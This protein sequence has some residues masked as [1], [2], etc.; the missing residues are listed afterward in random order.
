MIQ[1]GDILRVPLRGRA[2]WKARLL[3]RPLYTE[4]VATFA[5]HFASVMLEH[6]QKRLREPLI[7]R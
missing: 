1:P 4:R 7:Y 6:M 5:D 3:R 2:Y